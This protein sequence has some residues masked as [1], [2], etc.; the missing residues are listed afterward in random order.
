MFKVKLMMILTNTVFIHWKECHQAKTW[1]L[2]TESYDIH[3]DRSTDFHSSTH[4]Y[5]SNFLTRNFPCFEDANKTIFSEIK[6]GKLSI[7]NSVLLYNKQLSTLFN[8][9]SANITNV[10]THSKNSLADC[11]RIVW[12]CLTILWDWRLRVKGFFSGDG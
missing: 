4:P 12:L 2:E 8:P 1:S 3:F 7:N 6:K 11:R 10:Q 5:S 9:L